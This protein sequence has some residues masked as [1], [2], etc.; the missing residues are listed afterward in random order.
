MAYTYTQNECPCGSWLPWEPTWTNH[1]DEAIAFDVITRV[2]HR[3]QLCGRKFM[4]EMV[5]GDFTMGGHADKVVRGHDGH[6]VLSI[7]E[8]KA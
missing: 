1:E 7:T 4:V 5:P 2:A 6:P 8:A 3:C